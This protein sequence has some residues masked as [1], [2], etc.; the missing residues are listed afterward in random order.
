MN[1]RFLRE[2][3]KFTLYAIEQGES[4]DQFLLELE[5]ANP[6]AF[7]QILYRLKQLA[8]RGPSRKKDEFNTLGDELFE[9][10]AKSGPRIIFFY[11]MSKRQIIICSHGFDKQGQKTPKS[12]LKT[13]TGKMNAY[14]AHRKAGRDFTIHI[15]ENENPP[16]RLP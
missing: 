8:E 9:A 6:Q 1:L 14:Y 16:T 11:D 15:P 10:K 13:A 3:S 2:G 7:R 4:V 12:E 5:K